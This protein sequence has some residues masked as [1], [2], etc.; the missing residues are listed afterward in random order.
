VINR[1]VGRA[2]RNVVA[3]AIVLTFAETVH[4]PAVAF[5]RAAGDFQV[6]FS[7]DS[8]RGW[9]A[10]DASGNRVSAAGGI[11]RIDEDAG[12]L[13]TEQTKFDTFTLRF[14]VRALT[15]LTRAMVAILGTSPVKNDAGTA[16]VIPLFAGEVP[17]R[18]TYPKS[19]IT[20]LDLNTAGL[21]KALRP[22][23][24]WQA[25]AITRSE[26]RITASLNGALI[27]DQYGPRSLD[28]WIGFRTQRGPIEV[29]DIHLGPAPAA[30]SRAVDRPG[31]GVTLPRVLHEEKPRYTR[32]AM[33][34]R[35]QG[36]VL[37]ECVVEVDG[38]VSQ[39]V[40][41]RSLDQQYGLDAEAIRAARHWRFS[42]GTKDG[43]P[44]P[45]LVTIELTF[46]LGR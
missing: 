4:I 31:P 21:A 37:M 25:Y 30:S 10:D 40:V 22:T 12:W 13:R 33:Q 6:L 41:I 7:G 15:H 14:D 16:Y 20:L 42:P 38:T 8:L 34:Q 45:V 5:G 23:G 44:V 24:D 26:T 32:E 19:R 17:D 2:I 43:R 11:L 9:V 46:K 18:T 35:I 39:T 1:S 3:S 27:L 28:G 29:R 36:T